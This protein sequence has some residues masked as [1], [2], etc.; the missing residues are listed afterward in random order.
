MSKLI[1]MMLLAVASS[2]AV[3]VEWSYVGASNTG[4]S[5]YV[6][7]ANI[8]KKGNKVKIW[9]LKDFK[10]A[11]TLFG[12]TDTYLSAVTQ[13]EYDCEEHQFRL[14]YSMDHSKNM[15]NGNVVFVSS[16]VSAW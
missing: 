4:V 5:I 8:L 2:S 12:S 6:N 16:T 3:A 15:G 14:L 11:Q 1:L 10:T 13:S 9:D 7:P